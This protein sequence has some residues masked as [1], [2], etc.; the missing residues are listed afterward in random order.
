MAKTNRLTDRENGGA[1]FPKCFEA[2]CYGAGCAKENCEFIN[3]VCR[4]LCDLEDKL[5]SGALID[6]DGGY[7]L[8][9]CRIGDKIYELLEYD[10]KWE[11]CEEIVTEIGTKRIFTSGYDPAEDDLGVEIYISEIGKTAFFDLEEA[12]QALA[13]RRKN[14]RT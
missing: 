13:E 2:P 9:P 7:I 1:Y 14:G 12:K 6:N 10:G 8:L 4:R 5:E 3:E 11:I